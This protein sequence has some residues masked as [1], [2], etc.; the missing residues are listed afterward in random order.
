MDLQDKRTVPFAMVEVAFLRDPTFSTQEKAVYSLLIT[1]GPERIFPGHQT[2]ADQLGATRQSVIRW[3]N[4]LRERGMIDWDNR[5][6]TSNWYY[7]LGYENVQG[8]VTPVIQGCNTSD[9]PPCNTSD[10]R[11]RSIELDPIT[12]RA[13]SGDNEISVLEINLVDTTDLEHEC[14]SC[15]GVILV[16]E[17]RPSSGECPTCHLPVRVRDEHGQVIVKIPQGI[18]NQCENGRADWL[19]AVRS[20]CDLAHI[21]YANLRLHVRR[22]WADKLRELAAHHTLG[23]M[24]EAIPRLVVWDGDGQKLKSPFQSRFDRALT[25]H[26]LGNAQPVPE[27]DPE[28]AAVARGLR[29]I[30]E[31]KKTLGATR[32]G[33]VNG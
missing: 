21:Q 13:A 19:P 17:L 26:F 4:S 5:E 6:G 23:E 1:Y 28:L 11:S 25:E 14:P 18:R 8:G 16:Q 22:E 15:G 24:L 32:E 33:W 9:T 31:G 27:D 10:T 12:K 2:L 29:L 30:R 20:F 3:L 7:I